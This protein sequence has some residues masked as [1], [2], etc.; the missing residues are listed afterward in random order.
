MPRRTP[1]RVASPPLTTPNPPARHAHCTVPL[2]SRGVAGDAA[3][4]NA[5]G[6]GAAAGHSG[7]RGRGLFSLSLHLPAP[8]ASVV[9]LLGCS[10]DPSTLGTDA[11]PEPEAPWRGEG[12][13]SFFEAEGAARF[14]CVASARPRHPAMLTALPPT[15]DALGRH[16]TLEGTAGAAA[17]AAACAARRIRE[18]ALLARAGAQCAQ[19]APEM[20]ASL[21]LQKGAGGDCGRSWGGARAE[22]RREGASGRGE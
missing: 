15:G 8:Y 19:T 6:R 12:G 5:A 7:K 13:V 3:A 16:G 14:F 11:G 10:V 17:S 2:L 4:E 18:V 20:K 9:Q 1:R 22:E 21:P